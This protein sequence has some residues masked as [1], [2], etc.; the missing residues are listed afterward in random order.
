MNYSHGLVFDVHLCVSLFIHSDRQTHDRHNTMTIAHWIL[1][2]GAKKE[3]MLVIRIYLLFLQCFLP[4]NRASSVCETLISPLHSNSLKNVNFIFDL[5]LNLIHWHWPK[6]ILHRGIHMGNMKALSL[7]IWKLW[8]MLQFF[9]DKKTEGK[10]YGHT[11]GFALKKL[12]LWNY[13]LDFFQISQ[14]CSLG[15]LLSNSFK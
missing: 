1:A 15:G 4:F 9:I 12:L 8:P 11:H 6:R 14:E 10:V 7:M 5:D 3:K 13:W 2:S